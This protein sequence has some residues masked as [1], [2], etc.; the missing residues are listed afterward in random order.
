MARA[1]SSLPTPLSPRIRQVAL[2]PATRPICG[3]MSLIGRLVADQLAFD[4]QL[5]AQRAVLGRQRLLLLQLVDDAAQLL[6]DGDG[7]LEV[8]GVQRLERVGAV[9]VDQPEHLLAEDDRGA[10]Q[11]GGAQVA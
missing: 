3:S 4:V 7:E 1:T 5:V 6:G 2:V 11:A 8:L 10:D 9:K